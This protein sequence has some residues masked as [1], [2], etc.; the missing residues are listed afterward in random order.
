MGD[1]IGY[2]KIN[3]CASHDG[4]RTARPSG[5]LTVGQCLCLTALPHLAGQCPWAA[6]PGHRRAAR[7]RRSDGP[8]GHPCLQYAW[9]G[10]FAAW[11]VGAPSYAAGPL[12]RASARAAAD[13]APP[14]PTDLW[15]AYQCVDLA[16][17]GRRRLCRGDDA[18]SGQWRHDSPGLGR[19]QNALDTGHTVDHQ[20]RP[21]VCAEK[22]QRDR[23]IRLATTHPDWALGVAD[24][25]WWSRLAQPARHTWTPAATALRLVETARP[26]DDADPNA[27]ACDGWLVRARPTIPAPRWRRFAVGQPV[28]ALTTQV[29]AWCGAHLAARGLRALLLVWD[30]ASWH[31]S[32][33]VRTG[34]RDHNRQVKQRGC[35]VRVLPCR[36]PSQH[37]WLNPIE[38]QWVHGTRAVMEPVRL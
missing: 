14:E 37:P 6:G 31:T 13:P 17:G 22:K 29:L 18:P 36:L 23:L 27:L 24:D 4:C 11:V 35:G 32:P 38:P 34:I 33:Q 21:G 16:A 30:H 25:G 28:S 7:L 9:A 20:P 1:C 15:Q 10:D 8:Q 3:L 19:P 2:E 5:R 26:P 12:R